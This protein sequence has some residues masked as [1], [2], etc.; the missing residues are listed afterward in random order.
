MLLTLKHYSSI[1]LTEILPEY[2]GYNSFTR[3][4]YKI[5]NLDRSFFYV[6]DSEIEARFKTANYCHIAM[7]D[8]NKLYDL[9]ADNEQILLKAN[10]N[11]DKALRYIKSKYLG[12]IYKINDLQIA[13]IFYPITVEQI[14]EN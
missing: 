5:S 10:N 13:N 9:N 12:I 7:I 4:D 2:F 14:T 3:N 11:I 6:E 8:S 1:K